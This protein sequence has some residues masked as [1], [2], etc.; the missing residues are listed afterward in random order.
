MIEKVNI[1]GYGTNNYCNMKYA[2]LKNH[3]FQISCAWFV[4]ENLYDVKSG[5]IIGI[6]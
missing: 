3:F 2:L 6:M 5:C 1:A 4:K